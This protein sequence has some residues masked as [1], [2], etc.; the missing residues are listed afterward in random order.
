[1]TK[2]RNLRGI[3]P[4]LLGMPAFAQSPEFEVAAVKT[5]AE[6]G[7]QPMFASSRALPASVSRWKAA[8]WTSA[9]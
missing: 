9:S 7:R 6:P 2:G 3:L 5:A 1:M 8:V 4:I